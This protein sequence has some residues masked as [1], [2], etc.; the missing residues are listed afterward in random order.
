MKLSSVREFKKGLSAQAAKQAP[1]EFYEAL[2]LKHSP[3][4]AEAFRLSSE[5]AMPVDLALGVTMVGRQH[6]VAVRTTDPAL[7]EAIRKKANG[8][9]DVRIIRVEGRVTPA[10][11][12]GQRRPLEPG[13]SINTPVPGY[14]SA[15]TLGAIV[16]DAAGVLY[17]LSNS[18]VLADV[19]RLSIGSPVVQPGNLD[20]RITAKSVIGTL[21]RFIPIS[22]QTPNLVDCA[23]CR[24][25][26]TSFVKGFNGAIGAKIAGVRSVR[27]SDLGAEVT[28]IGRTTGVRKGTITTV[29]IDGLPV[30]MDQGFTPRFNDQIEISGGPATNFSDSGDSGSL[31]LDTA[32]NA[33]GLLFAGGRDQH[34]E[35]FTY[36]NLLTNVLEALA[37]ELVL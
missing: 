16:K 17:A 11:L 2:G 36:A 15:G 8:E 20:G 26:G 27:P 18:H 33:L 34:G 29:E 13:Q 30:A 19:G 3:K 5:P 6:A 1:V 21:A 12:Q 23:L 25:A 24:L 10:Y 9:A 37:V 28:K 31:I 35:D 4:L 14:R 32:G 7:G 22:Q